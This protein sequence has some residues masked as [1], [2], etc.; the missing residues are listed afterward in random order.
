[1]VL[2]WAK[3]F[4]I[5]NENQIS[6]Q[7]FL[8]LSKYRFVARADGRNVSMVVKVSRES[9]DLSLERTEEM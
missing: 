4:R 6:D 3:Q 2:Q 9:T 1:M 7:I 5:A 8:R